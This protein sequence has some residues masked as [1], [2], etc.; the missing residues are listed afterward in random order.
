MDADTKMMGA[1]N[2]F[3][4]TRWNLVWTSADDQESLDELISMYWKPLYFFVRQHGFDNETSKDIVQ[5]FLAAAIERQSFPK[6]DPA[7]GRFRTFLTASL[8]NSMRDRAKAGS[9]KK[10]G[11]SR[12]LLSLDFRRGESDYALQAVGSESPDEVLSRAWARGLWEEALAEVKAEPAQLKAFQL[13]LAG[14]DYRSIGKVTGLSE[15]KVNSAIRRVK[16]EIKRLI[17]GRLQKTV[18]GPEELRAEL[19]DFRRLLSTGPRPIR[20]T[21]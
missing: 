4:T 12:A 7:R 20:A 17:T 21:V 3:E 2:Q 10:R 13:Y 19:A 11:G 5:D 14:K 18:S 6:A 16:V 1:R 15:T 8:R 9:R